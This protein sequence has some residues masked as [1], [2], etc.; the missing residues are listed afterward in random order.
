VYELRNVGIGREEQDDVVKRNRA[1]E[2]EQEPCLEVV[3]GYLTRLEDDLVSEIVGNDTCNAEAGAIA[4]H[5]SITH[6]HTQ[7]SER[8][9]PTQTM[10]SASRPR[11]LRIT[12]FQCK[13]STRRCSLS[14]IN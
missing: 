14:L 13:K 11:C 3:L 4:P 7:S 9:T 2:I 5:T 6:T 8:K 12:L 10:M 1:D